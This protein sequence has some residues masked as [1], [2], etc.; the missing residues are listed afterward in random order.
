MRINKLQSGSKAQSKCRENGERSAECR[1]TAAFGIV[2]GS[3]LAHLIDDE[4]D[5]WWDSV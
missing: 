3:L 2:V 1:V 5:E 4:D